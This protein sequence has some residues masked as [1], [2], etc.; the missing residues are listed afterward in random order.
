VQDYGDVVVHVFDA[1]A[2]TYY[3][4]EDLWADARGWTGRGISPIL[5]KPAGES[6]SLRG[7]SHQPRRLEDSPAGLIDYGPLL[8]L[9]SA[10]GGDRE[11]HAARMPLPAPGGL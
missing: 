2:R 11:S 4:L 3:S 7:D 10:P 8:R 9:R 6:S 5:R 1:E